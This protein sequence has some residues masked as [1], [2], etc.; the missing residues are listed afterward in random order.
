[1]NWHNSALMTRKWK[2]L[3]LLL[4]CT[5]RPKPLVPALETP[6]TVIWLHRDVGAEIAEVRVVC[7]GAETHDWELPLQCCLEGSTGQGTT[8]GKSVLSHS[9]GGAEVTT[10]ESAS[11]A[12]PSPTFGGWISF[13]H[14]SS[15]A[16]IW[17]PADFF[18]NCFVK[19]IIQKGVIQFSIDH[20]NQEFIK[21]ARLYQSDR[22]GMQ[23][24]SRTQVYEAE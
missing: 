16:P 22:A 2:G 11:H 23:E 19:D 12:V 14:F 15:R 9:A 13:S 24:T 21:A 6:G 8:L 3:T 7:C 4:R 18:K 1:M 10:A 5:G 17:N 20:S